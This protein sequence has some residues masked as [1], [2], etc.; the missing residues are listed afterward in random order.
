MKTLD[1]LGT[2]V[3]KAAKALAAVVAPSAARPW[4]SPE[5]EQE[6]RRRAEV[7]ARGE[8]TR[9]AL[10]AELFG[11]GRWLNR[12]PGWLERRR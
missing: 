4:R 3:R 2:G 1:V 7:N 8:A 6:L 9:A 12:R 11:G 5:A 10:E